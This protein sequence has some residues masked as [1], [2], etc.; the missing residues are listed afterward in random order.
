MNPQKHR[1][2]LI[3]AITA[4]ALAVAGLLFWWHARLT[5]APGDVAAFLD[6][7]SGS[8][9]VR[10]TVVKIET[11]RKD[12]AGQQVAVSAKAWP[13]QPLYTRA[14]TPDYL[15]RTFQFDADS[16][17]EARMLLADKA[18]ARNPRLTGGRPLPPDP[19]QL[20]VLQPASQADTSFNFQ[21]V[22]DAHR[23]GGTWS[24][25]LVS[26]GLEG[27]G[28][29][30]E[31]RATF[32]LPSF[33]AGDAAD[34]TR[35]RSIIADF[36]AFNARVAKG[37]SDSEAAHNAAV[38]A[39]RQAFL[40]RIAPGRFFTGTALEAGEQYGTPLSLEITGLSGDEVTAV[41][42][43]DGSWHNARVFEGSWG[44]DDDFRTPILTLNS[45]S[46]QA[47]RN[48]GPFLEN[49]QNW[50][51]ALGMDPFG[52]LSEQNRF[53]RY[54]FQPAPPAQMTLLRTRLEAEFEAAIAAT[55]P[56]SLYQG[57]ATSRTSGASDA[58]L[59]RITSRADDGKTFDATIES[60]TR[61]WKRAFHGTII[62]NARRS[63]G[64]PVRMSSSANDAAVDAPVE[65]VL[66]D[67]DDLQIGLNPAG[68]ALAGEGALFTYQFARAEETD[69]S[70]LA[71]GRAERARHFMAVM[72]NGIAYDGAFREDQGFITHDR[73][74]IDRV[75]RATG[76]ITAII[77]SLGRTRVFRAFSGTC[78]PAGGSVSL[79]ATGRGAFIEDGSFDIPFLT[80]PSA[81]TLHL[82]LSGNSI[83][84]RIEGDPHWIM[85]FPA[86]SF[87]SA[88]TES[89]EPNSPPANGS[90][91]PAF[92]KADGAYLLSHGSWSPMPKN[93]GHVTI[94]T[95]S[96]KS[97]LE[98]PNN[99]IGAVNAGL[100]AFSTKKE[101]QKIA[102]L[103]FDGKDPRPESSAPAMVIL[104]VGAQ[105]PG[106]VRFELAPA[107]LQKDGTRRI[108]IPGGAAMAP[109]KPPANAAPDANVHVKPPEIRLGDELLAAYVRS[110]GPGYILFTTTSTLVPG[111][112]VFNADAPYELTQE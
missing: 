37:R 35:L 99:L 6:A 77:R 25:S 5:V 64:E 104:V 36:Q 81:S 79:V 88:T 21:G 52:R 11:L 91:F 97:D 23:T 24:F 92:P 80:S 7:T 19:Y 82:E 14:D 18:T 41:L 71:A 39:R 74:E 32:G 43:N 105:H 90:V 75:D 66:G 56:G 102:Y 49:T 72:R 93:N 17:A 78:D 9:R 60:P 76:A 89:A 27:G 108:E 68:G 8:G 44:A 45:T 53:Y 13:V 70:R 63:R 106:K 33:V 15:L 95:L 51:L 111:P 94:V 2:I 98:L 69:L 86:G 48:A 65:S 59:L 16:T 40:M 101:K 107:E 112:Y 83:T 62:D 50:T 10:F 54:E 30:G 20:V 67:Q 110:A 46:G 58:V 28:P 34:E 73:L 84:G 47:V 87:L 4:L 26:G 22:L 100:T 103:V 29:L 57:H 38:E 55:E 1:K 31:A 96:E 61:S 109:P 3:A 85:E 42:R 12:D